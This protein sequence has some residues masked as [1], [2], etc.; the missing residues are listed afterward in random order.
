MAYSPYLSQPAA[1]ALASRPTSYKDRG[2]GGRVG[3]GRKARLAAAAVK[4]DRRHSDGGVWDAGIIYDADD[5]VQDLGFDDY[6]Q[7]KVG[8]LPRGWESERELA[9]I[10]EDVYDDIDE[11]E[12]DALMGADVGANNSVSSQPLCECTSV[13]A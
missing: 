10:D 12:S 1:P 6:M 4:S 9:D 2:G 8:S 3:R 13:D 5:H 7:A 11:D